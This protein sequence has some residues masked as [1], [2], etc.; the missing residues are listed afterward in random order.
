M[1]C[2]HHPTT[3]TWGPII[4][5]SNFSVRPSRYLLVPVTVPR[6]RRFDVCR[7]GKRPD[8]SDAVISGLVVVGPSQERIESL[9]TFVCDPSDS[10][11]GNE[12]GSNPQKCRPSRLH[13]LPI[14]SNCALTSELFWHCPRLSVRSFRLDTSKENHLMFTSYCASPSSWMLHKACVMHLQNNCKINK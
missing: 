4:T 6:N 2:S 11:A 9:A 13:R 14:S 10:W 5:F 1:N 8:S 12:T 3:H 7:F